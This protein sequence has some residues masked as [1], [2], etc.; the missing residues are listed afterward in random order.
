MAIIEYGNGIFRNT[1]VIGGNVYLSPLDGAQSCDTLWFKTVK[2]AK[3]FVEKYGLINGHEAGV[4][5]QCKCHYSYGTKEWTNAPF[6][7]ACKRWKKKIK[8]GLTGKPGEKG[9]G[10]AHSSLVPEEPTW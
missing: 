6:D 10:S 7:Y 1:N 3:Q 2:Q 8:A 4:C 9:G 5:N